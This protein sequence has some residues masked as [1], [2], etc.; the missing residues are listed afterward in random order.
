MQK[1]F[2]TSDIGCSEKIDGK[3][4]TKPLDNNNNFI[5][6]VK[7]NI[8]NEETFMYITSSPSNYETND[9]YANITFDSFNMSGF[10]FKNLIIVDYRY[11]GNLKEDIKKTDIIFLSGGHTLTEMKFFEEI[12]L[13]DLLKD[14]DGVIIGQSAGSLNL[15][16][17]VVCSPESDEEIGTNYIWRGLEKTS[18]NIEPH[19]TLH[20][21]ECDKK[22]REELLK[23]SK[24]YPMYALCDGS[25]ILDN[26]KT[27][28]LYGETYYLKNGNIDKV[29]N[30][31]ECLEL[32]IHNYM[33][34]NIKL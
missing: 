18:I 23:I 14:Y 15:A 21:E 7:E 27:I 5:K 13:R 25:Y 16:Q 34:G 1:V 4:C 29:C 20:A 26:G 28:T 22:L 33:K 24:D 31:G 2:L 12:K 3:R 11:N 30:D 32:E 19:F 17:T 10:N 6:K 9:S 8:K